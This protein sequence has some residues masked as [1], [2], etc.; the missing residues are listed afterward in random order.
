MEW[1]SSVS[2]KPPDK[3]LDSDDMTEGNME[4][5]ENSDSLSESLESSCKTTSMTSLLSMK[6]YASSNQSKHRKLLSIGFQSIQPQIG[7]F[8]LLKNFT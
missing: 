5:D 7:I 1:L 2:D 8:F 6:S 3:L 4:V